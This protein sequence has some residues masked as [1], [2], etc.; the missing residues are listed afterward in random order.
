LAGLVGSAAVVG[1]YINPGMGEWPG[2]HQSELHQSWHGRMAGT[3]SI[4]VSPGLY[5]AYYLSLQLWKE[6]YNQIWI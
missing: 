4:S 2:L 5:L 3:L 6:Y 1:N